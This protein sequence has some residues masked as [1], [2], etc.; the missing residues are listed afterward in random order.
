MS[1]ACC[2]LLYILLHFLGGCFEQARVVA[3]LD[4][5]RIRITLVGKGK[6][7]IGCVDGRH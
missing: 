7:G 5:G 4:E 3:Y 2:T 1:V 6:E